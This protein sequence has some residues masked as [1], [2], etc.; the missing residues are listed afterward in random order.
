MLKISS[1][2]G[3]VEALVAYQ[4]GMRVTHWMG[5]F[6]FATVV[7]CSPGPRPGQGGPDLGVSSLM[8]AGTKGDSGPLPSMLASTDAGS[9]GTSI[10]QTGCSCGTVG[11]THQCY[12]G[13]A[14]QAG[15][16]TC[17]WGTQTCGGAAEFPVWGACTGY[18]APTPSGCDGVDH[19]CDGSI[20]QGCSCPPNSSK[21]CYAGP[22]GTVGVGICKAGTQTC[23][24]NHGTSAWGPCLGAVT[25]AHNE[26]CSG[27]TD[28]TCDGKVGCAD[29][30]CSCSC[31]PN[32]KQSCYTGPSGTE[33]VGACKPGMQECVVSST[34]AKWGDCNGEVLPL[35]PAC[36]SEVDTACDGTPGC[37]DPDCASSSACPCVPG[38]QES[39][40]TGPTGTE[41]VGTCKAGHK[42]CTAT[43]TGSKWGSCTGQVLPTTQSCTNDNDT[44]CD[45]TPGCKDPSCA[46]NAACACTGCCASQKV[47]FV[48]CI[49]AGLT[50]TV[51]TVKPGAFSVDTIAC[52]TVSTST[53]LNAYDTIVYVG[54]LSPAATA[55]FPAA[56]SS[57]L[58]AGAKVIFFPTGTC[59]GT[60]G[61]TC[62]FGTNNWQT[63]YSLLYLEDN[64]EY[65]P[66]IGASTITTP[67]TDSMSSA[68]SATTYSAYDIDHIMFNGTAAT[69]YLDYPS[70]GNLTG[71]FNWCSDLV[72]SGIGKTTSFHGYL[73]DDGTRKGLLIAGTL[74][75][76]HAGNTFDFSEPFLAAHLSQKWNQ[77]GNSTACGLVCSTTTPF[78]PPV[79]IAKP[80]IYLYPTKEEE[81]SV[82]LDLDGTLV[83][84]YPK[85]VEAQH[86][87][88][89]RARP[90]G[91]LVNLA[92]G[93]EY[94]YIYWTGTSSA[95]QP[96]FDEGFVVRG[97]DTRAFL[98]E[99]LSKMG[100]TPRE[101]N[102][103]IVYWL[104]YMESHP[105][106]LIS[107]AHESYTNVARLRVEPRP[108]S[109]L[110][111]FMV[112]KKLDAPFDVRPQKI[113]PFHRKGF[114][115][116]EW[117]GAE[118]GGDSHVLH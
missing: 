6:L 51:L 92:D 91:E 55:D 103:M 85:Y 34:G 60:S 11:D 113:E 83:T 118:I 14:F 25:P 97:E 96:S 71:T 45:G 73:L 46:N 37:L 13:P 68:F 75:F 116:V 98:R 72:A 20:N 94:S 5:A 2:A 56:V 30:T 29:P 76:V 107:F 64:M 86:G 95:F 15:L 19:A 106:N 61:G 67:N 40:Y 58:A 3:K 48:N 111:V 69:S 63:I 89:V 38:A 88:T 41:G 44:A 4:P 18:G 49:P 65:S 35:A 32:S 26:D 17:T 110:R 81:V 21:S 42:T 77:A 109:M 59:D 9:C 102:D 28:N 53:A 27:T 62:T 57:R 80:V 8:D 78:T 31:T 104:P 112:W 93:K 79:G 70:G 54:P 66:T 50:S 43:S 100:L 114:A 84:T 90:D 47:A 22:S 115:V 16:G 108:D 117:G 101:Y 10:D 33:G 99:T 52:S 24:T 7:G 23:I 36:D 105:Y 39:C 12:V 87:W 74:D 82:R 1:R